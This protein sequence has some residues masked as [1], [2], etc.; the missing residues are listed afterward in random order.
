MKFRHGMFIQIS[1]AMLEYL[2]VEQ[3]SISNDEIYFF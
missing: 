2:L 1:K 3:I